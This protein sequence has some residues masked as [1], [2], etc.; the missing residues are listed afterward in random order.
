MISHFHICVDADRPFRGGELRRGRQD[1]HPVK[2]VPQEGRW[3][4]GAPLRLQPRR[5]RDQGHQPRRLGAQ[6]AQDERAE[7]VARSQ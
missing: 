2:G 4:R 5:G 7:A 6:D 1:L 3:R